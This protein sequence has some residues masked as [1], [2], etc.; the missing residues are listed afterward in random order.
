VR[1]LIILAVIFGIVGLVVGYLIFG[2]LEFTNELIPVGQLFSSG[3]SLF[4]EIGRQIAGFQ[5]KRQSI[6]ISGGVGVLV[7]GVLGFALRRRR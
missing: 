2:R 7:G 5:A 6:Y 1:N 3:N 4:G